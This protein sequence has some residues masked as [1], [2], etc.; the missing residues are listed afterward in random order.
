MLLKRLGEI[1][2]N[3]KLNQNIINASK[4]ELLKII[5]EYMAKEEDDRLQK[6]LLK[7]IIESYALNSINL[8]K[9]L[10]NM[11][12]LSITDALTGI[13]NR[14]KFNEELY[15]S[16]EKF[17]EKAEKFSLIMFDI[18]HFKKVNDNFGHDVG[19][20]VLIEICKRVKNSIRKKDIFARWGGEEF[21]LLVPE[22]DEK[23]TVLLAERLRKEIEKKDFEISGK[24]TCSFGVA[25][26]LQMDDEESITKR[27]DEALY[28]S[29]K[30]GRNKTTY[31]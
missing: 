11:T 25:S 1:L 15:S 2:K 30:N 17:R 6:R 21:I 9:A 12:K 3:L 19:D 22:E 26:F 27:V 8:K 13:Y 7:E 10:E 4:A 14:I 29:K 24:I 5:I 20:K 28:Y 31:L 16:I 18:D 23:F